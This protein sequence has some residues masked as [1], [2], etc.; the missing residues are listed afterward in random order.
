MTILTKEK[1]PLGV[2]T[3]QKNHPSSFEYGHEDALVGI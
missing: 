2:N 1:G 3:V